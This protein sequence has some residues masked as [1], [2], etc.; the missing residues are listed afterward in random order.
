M[1]GKTLALA[2]G[3][4]GLGAIALGTLLLYA[5]EPPPAPEPP[6]PPPPPE[7]TMNSTLKYS[8][9]VYR[10]LIETD[11]R[12]YKVPIPSD[13]QLAQPNRYFEELK[14]HRRLRAKDKKGA[15]LE[16]AH[17]RLTTTIAKKTAT[18]EGQTYAVDHLVLRIENRT[19]KYLAYR[20]E[21]SVTDKHKCS[22]K[23]DIA[24]N[25]LVLEPNQTV[26]RT[27]CLYRS[28]ENI[29]VT[30]VEVIEL[31]P[32]AAYY[33]SRLPANPTLYDPRT[34]AG[35]TPLV[36][37]LCPQT[38]SWRDIQEGIEKREI[39]WRDV[40]DFYTRHNCDEYS[41]FRSYRYRT[42]AGDPLPARPLD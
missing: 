8:P 16:T 34:S 20:I 22:A 25:A 9:S 11:A 17:L 35:H 39:G 7:V 27:E 3:G 10:A 4:A 15:S 1:E 24:H 6:K 19:D 2:V 32:L 42:K 12:T 18:L 36:L 23:G 29:D 33:V 30:H 21:T 37:A 31:P 41:F 13:G 14:G 28:D 26:Q 5:G 38:F 40:I